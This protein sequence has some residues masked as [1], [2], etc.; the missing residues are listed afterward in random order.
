MTL[1]TAL[2]VSDRGNRAFWSLVGVVV[3]FRAVVLLLACC[4]LGAIVTLLVGSGPAVLVAGAWT[5]PAVALAVLLVLAELVGAVRLFGGLFADWELRRDLRVRG[6]PLGADVT[7]RVAEHGLTGR[8]IVVAAAEPFAFT[9]G[10]LAPRVVLSDT[11][12]R[13]LDADELGAV[14][15]HESAHVRSHDPL[16]VLIARTL[17]AREFYLPALR[18]LSRRFVAG[19]ELAADRHA[20]SHVGVNAIAGALLHTVGPPG[21]AAATPAMASATTLHARITQ[22]ETGVEPA[23]SSTPRFHLLATVVIGTLVLLAGVD[24]AVL[25]RQVCMSG[26]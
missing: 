20:V 16:K 14:L 3:V 6:V 10:L 15:A 26:M 18:D 13:R 17:I 12:V 8:V 19:R 23:P 21:W 11:L 2:S 9:C 24:A 22:L 25:V 5:L 4:L 7:A 1:P